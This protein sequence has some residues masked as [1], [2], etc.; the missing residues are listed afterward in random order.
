VPYSALTNHPWF[1]LK[2]WYVE[3]VR[4]MMYYF[5]HRYHISA[6]NTRLFYKRELYN[7]RVFSYLIRWLKPTAEP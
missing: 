1:S 2:L 5:I 7:Q 4:A 3:T 6:T